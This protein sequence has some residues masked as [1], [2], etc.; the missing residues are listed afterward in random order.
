MMSW[1]LFFI[2][3]FIITHGLISFLKALF[4]LQPTLDHLHTQHFHCQV[5]LVL[6]PSCLFT[7]PETLSEAMT[8]NHEGEREVE[9]ERQKLTVLPQSPWKILSDRSLCFFSL[10][11]A[12]KFTQLISL[13]SLSLN[14]ALCVTAPITQQTI[15]FY[16]V[17]PHHEPITLLSYQRGIR[18]IYLP[19]TVM[20]L[21][22]PTVMFLQ[23]STY[24][25][26][27]TL[28]IFLGL[29]S[30]REWLFMVNQAGT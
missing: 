2:L 1:R 18:V 20:T 29:E 28:C 26:L 8:A 15:W 23:V 6:L 13:I 7:Q 17:V 12:Q 5:P 16:V 9:V 3:L 14:A 25:S 24:M 19:Y 21:T 10:S 27:S 11:A 22:V 4:Q 30:C